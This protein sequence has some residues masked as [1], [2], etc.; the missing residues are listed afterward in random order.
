VLELFAIRFCPH[1]SKI[2]QWAIQS[3]CR[4]KDADGGWYVRTHLTTS[5]KSNKSVY[6]NFCTQKMCTDGGW[7]V[8][9]HVN[10]ALQQRNICLRC[11]QNMI[12][13]ALPI[14]SMSPNEN[15]KLTYDIYLQKSTACYAN[16][17]S[18]GKFA[19]S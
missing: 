16:C 18:K 3:G 19:I 14:S 1:T 6:F 13:A 4:M 7:R 9:T 12:V 11:I 10:A 8:S 5:I 15:S 17:C 2:A